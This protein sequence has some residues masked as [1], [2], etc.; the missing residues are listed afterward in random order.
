MEASPTTLSA[1]FRQVRVFVGFVARSFASFYPILALTLLVVILEYAATSLMIPLSASAS[2]R[3]SSTTQLWQGVLANLGMQPEPRTWLWLFF[4]VMCVRQIFGYAQTVLTTQLGKKVHRVLSGR[5]FGHV[6]SAEPLKSVY[7]RSVGHYIT[8]AGDDTSRCGTIIASLLQCLV[9]LATA[10]VAIAILYQFSPAV[11]AAVGGFL[12]LCAVTILVL[13]RYVLR[14]NVRANLLS[15]ELNT[16]FVEALNSLRSIRALHAERF[17][18]NTYAGQIATYVRMLFRIEAIRAGIKSFPAILLLLIAAILMQQ[19]SS[20][21]LSEASLLAV[22]IIVIRIFAAMGQFIGAGT[23]LLTDIRAIHDIGSLVR[24][25]DEDPHL[26]TPAHTSVPLESMAL[27]DIDF[28]YAGRPRI[29]T[30]FTFRFDKGRTYAVVGPSGIGKST[31]ADLMLGLVAPDRG[32]VTINAGRLPVSAA[33][34]R[35]LLVEQQPKIFSTSVR[36]NLLFGYAAP[37]ERLWEALRHVDLEDF[38]R[39]LP[40]GLDTVLS[41]QGENLSGGQRQRIGIARAL[42]RSPDLLILDEATSALD[43]ATRT[44]VLNNVRELLRGGVLVMITHD[45]YLSQLADVVLD[46]RTLGIAVAPRTAQSVGS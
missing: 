5:I 20:L 19:G 26:P 25:A 23:L 12:A 36:D 44:T 39:Q 35:L 11:F 37:D 14:L 21:T 1:A 15:R 17:V 18:R 45:A 29:L 22:T 13:F 32:T 33:Y 38:V 2:G 9:T 24:T 34:G 3:G 46:F 41:Y 31:L 8:L 40:R 7:V 43:S 16:L 27:E 10:L 4:I 28:G 42:V 30:N 6:V